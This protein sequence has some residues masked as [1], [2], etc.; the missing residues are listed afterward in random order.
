[1]TQMAADFKKNV[2][3]DLICDI[4]VICG[5]CFDLSHYY[6]PSFYFPSFL[7]LS[8]DATPPGMKISTATKM[9]N[10]PTGAQPMPI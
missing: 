1:M 6:F 5:Q 7:L 9:M 4:C 8:S 10:R 3:L 2:A